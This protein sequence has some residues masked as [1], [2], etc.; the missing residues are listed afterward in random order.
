MFNNDSTSCFLR[1]CVKA[2]WYLA[3]LLVLILSISNH[4]IPVNPERMKYEGKLLNY[5]NQ[6]IKINMERLAATAVNHTLGIYDF[7]GMSIGWRSWLLA[8]SFSY[9]IIIFIR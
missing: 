6:I 7:K 9:E 5:K 2:G 3:V 8:N 4:I 1:A